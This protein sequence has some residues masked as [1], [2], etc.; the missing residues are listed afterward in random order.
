MPSAF[1]HKPALSMTPTEWTLLLVLSVLWGGSFY[2]AKIAVQDIP[3]LTLALGRVGIAAL[4][5]AVVARVMAVPFP[6]DRGTWWTFTVIAALNNVVP[7]TLIFWGQIYLSIGLASILNATSPLFG[8]LVAHVLTQDDRLNAGRVIGLIAGFLGVV[9]LIGP[10][11]LS[12]LGANVLAELALLASSVSYAFGAVYA[13][14]A[15]ALSPIVVA[16]GQLS[17]STVLLLPIVL[18]FDTPSVVLTAPAAAIWAMVGIALLSSALA[19]LIYFRILVR[20]GATNALLV[21]FLVPVS[22]IMLGLVLLDETI[23]LRQLAGMAAIFLG[24]AAIDGR[25]ARFF[26]RVSSGRGSRHQD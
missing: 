20:S 7:F 25:P 26:A 10:D 15:R 1:P 18:L 14:R 19:Y 4:A 2:F 6:R 9:V 11:L 5:L 8:V 13:R 12:E 21:T 17:M 16:T 3:P 22:A 23:D 24:L